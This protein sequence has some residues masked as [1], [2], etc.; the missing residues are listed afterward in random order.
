MGAH[1][2]PGHDHPHDHDHDHGHH[3]HH[4]DGPVSAFADTSVPDSE[5]SASDRTRRS[6][7]RGA[8]LLGV[9]IASVGGAASALEAA[10]QS[11]AAASPPTATGGQLLWSA[12]DHHTH[13][14]YSAGS[15]APYR[16]DQ[17]VTAAARYGLG[18][19]VVTDHGG[20]LHQKF[21]LN[22]S[23][24]D[25]RLS[26][27]QNPDML[28]FQGMEW[29]VPAG[30]HCTLFVAP[31]ANEAIVLTEFEALF[32]SAI[33]GT[34]PSSPANEAKALEAVR[35]LGA[36]VRAGRVDMGLTVLNHPSRAGAYAPSELRA[37]RDADPSVAIGMEGAPG[38]Q[39]AGI[40]T[41]VGGAGGGR[42]GYGGGPGA[43]SFA[44]YP[45]E[46]YSTFGGFD[47]LTAKVG[48][49]WDSMLAE[50]LPFWVTAT[51]DSHRVF[52]DTWEYGGA[53]SAEGVYPDPV[54][55]R[56]PVAG[57]GDYWPGQY[58]RTHLG[59]RDFS[60]LSVMRA[61]RAGR[62]WVDHGQLIDSL[63]VSVGGSRRHPRG[64]LGEVVTAS[65]GDSVEVTV[66]IGLPSRPNNNGDTPRL[67]RVDLIAGPVTGAA[68]DR[69]T[70]TA[71]GTRVVKSFEIS[72]RTGTVE[73]TYRFRKV[74][75]PFYLRLRGTDG[76]YSATGSIEPR[77]DPPG[78]ADPWTDLWFYSNPVF[79]AVEGRR[80]FNDRHWNATRG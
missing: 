76:R 75:E 80:P 6:F 34:R 54:F 67:R 51:S 18:W 53:P 36:Q 72:Q 26:R 43:D 23:L 20:A 4:H 56:T 31:G 17:H 79:V 15:D 45:L 2:H 48:G 63:D 16:V 12:G 65:R 68:A 42:G 7:L 69:D 10:T 74:D 61:L 66:R 28:V 24:A 38:H 40:P 41:A 21:G 22:Q 59:L 30:E 35:W 14:K 57:R 55:T 29:N 25:V 33:N 44:G 3:H 27:D 52:G 64:T 47:W 8:G 77:L 46:S 62:I 19:L 13:T 58:S 50:G 39:A 37:L 78:A 60:Y 9:G 1:H 32:D 71:P 11:S 49:V 73:L 5:L 70:L